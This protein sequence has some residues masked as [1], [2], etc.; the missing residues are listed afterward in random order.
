MTLLRRM[1]MSN[2]LRVADTG[3]VEDN[4]SQ[5]KKKKKI[6][7]I[8]GVM[9][10]LDEHGNPLKRL[11]KK[12]KDGGGSDHHDSGGG[13]GGSGG[14]SI[15]N[16]R[17]KKNVQEID[18]QLWLLDDDGNPLK[19][20][21][22][23]SKDGDD[24]SD[25]RNRRRAQSRGRGGRD[26]PRPPTRSKSRNAGRQRGRSQGR[27]GSDSEGETSSSD[28]REGN[29][30]R[31]RQ[32]RRNSMKP[33][34]DHKGYESDGGK[35]LEMLMGQS[36]HGKK[37]KK[38]VI[39]IDGQLWACDENG[40]PVKKVRRKGGH[41]A[42][43]NTNN[44]RARSQSRGRVRPQAPQRSKSEGKPAPMR[45]GSFTDAKGR[46]HVFE[47]GI[48]SVFDKNGKKLRKKGQPKHSNS[49][50]EN[51]KNDLRDDEPKTKRKEEGKREVES[52]D[53]FDH[54]WNDDDEDGG[55]TKSHRESLPSKDWSDDG[56][57]FSPMKPR[58]SSA[59][60][61]DDGIRGDGHTSQQ[62]SEIDK[63][64]RE[65]QRELEAAKAEMESMAEKH[66]KE[67]AK[68]VKAMTDMMQ[69][70][71]DYHDA[72]SE[73]LQLRNKVTDLHVLIEDKEKDLEKAKEEA[74]LANC[75]NGE[76][77]TELEAEKEKMESKLELERLASQTEI[78]KKE[79]QLAHLNRELGVL[80]N[81]LEMLITGK[82]G[83]VEVD[84]MMARLIQEK[85]EFE[86]KYNQEKEVNSI[87]ISSL[88]E[89][90][91]TL[92]TMNTELNKEMLMRKST[93][94]EKKLMMDG[95]MH[96][97]N[98]HARRGR[99]GADFERKAPEPSRS[100]DISPGALSRRF[101]GAR[102]ETT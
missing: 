81:E 26:I 47:N 59:K 44:R 82:R 74:P 29:N 50:S 34:R 12:S 101:F 22:K 52:F 71:A 88:Q 67:K 32:Q 94:N 96:S 37:K 41:E 8:D 38:Q 36:Q 72:N 17:K 58:R 7:E 102:E 65:L 30:K 40:K 4:G 84:P 51:S 89:M 97:N 85:K 68:N 56:A 48:E 66:R 87:K 62:I 19:K 100:F 73:L 31:R 49:Q 53:I 69:L 9:W 90:I 42:D 39:E 5:K 20:V 61:L 60:A 24:S 92:E 78:R 93:G 86:E 54:L 28:G 16:R 1:S 70:K 35:S 45:N 98:I 95:S 10:E 75:D 23:K 6:M 21:R 33:T 77:I 27:K 64:N 55:P 91:D 80:R 13:R 43:T 76:Q 15:Q 83:N 99:R 14:G 79:E 11:K 18:G 25:D 46:R 3:T 2:P 57:P 63:R